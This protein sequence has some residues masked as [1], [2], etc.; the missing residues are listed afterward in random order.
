[1]AG[2]TA[3]VGMGSGMA[4]PAVEFGEMLFDL[5]F[6]P[7]GDV[8]AVGSVTGDVTVVGFGSQ[9]GGGG[10]PWSRVVHSLRGLHGGES[11]RTVRFGWDG[12]CLYTGGGDNAIHLVDVESGQTTGTLAKAHASAVNCLC[13]CGSGGGLVASGDDDGVVRFW[14]VR[15]ARQAGTFERC[16]TDFVSDM[17]WVPEVGHLL[18]TSGD[19]TLASFDLRKLSAIKGAQR[20]DEDEELLSVV[21]LKRGKKV[22]CGTQL[23][24]LQIF[25]WGKLGDVTDRFP[26][27]PQSVDTLL[28]I[29]EGTV[30]SGSSDGLVR[31]LSIQP[32][33][34]LGVVGEHADFPVERIAKSHDGWLL[35]SIS[36][37]ET[38]RFWDI[39]ALSADG[40]CR[41]DEEKEE[42]VGH[43]EDASGRVENDAVTVTKGKRKAVNMDMSESGS[44]F[45]SEDFS[46]SSESSADARSN[47][48]RKGGRDFS[49]GN[50]GFFDGL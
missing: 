2:A 45:D 30:C 38:L 11:C 5:D 1:M 27:H 9:G 19:G 4:P 39:S 6:S 44:E 42:D 35:G 7:A 12:E 21:C 41:G 17:C 33:K 3:G 50:N 43:E 49:P 32:N 40:E 37:D 20:S 47:K 14:D 29:D 8:C 26:G 36:H 28:K 18:A 13:V 22:V 46:D 24:V 10:E 34:M 16:Q 23:G 25:S 15:Q 48:V 31:V